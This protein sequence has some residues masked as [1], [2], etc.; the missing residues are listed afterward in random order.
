MSTSIF[1]QDVCDIDGVDKEASTIG[2]KWLECLYD[3]NYLKPKTWA[4]VV[5]DLCSTVIPLY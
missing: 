4:E 5:E 2:R 1:F 3:T